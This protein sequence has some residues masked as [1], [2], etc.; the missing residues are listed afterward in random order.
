M[1][2]LGRKTSLSRVEVWALA[3]G[4]IIG[5]GAFVMPGSTFLPDAGPFGSGIA[6]GLGA[7]I[8]CLIAFNFKYMMNRYPSSG[9]PF[10][11]TSKVFGYDHGFVCAWFLGL[12]Y[13]RCP[14]LL[15]DLIPS[16]SRSRDSVFP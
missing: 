16:R 11:Y 4:S 9:G 15:W 5:W 8:M 7:V 12:S 14:G 13:L 2:S 10:L 6:L 3:F 1:E